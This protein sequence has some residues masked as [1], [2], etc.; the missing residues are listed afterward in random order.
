MKT[1]VLLLCAVVFVYIP[2]SP[3]R[4]HREITLDRVWSIDPVAAANSPTAS[5]SSENGDTTM[6]PFRIAD[7]FGYVAADGSHSYFGEVSFDVTIAR[8]GFVNY[9]SLGTNLV[10]QAPDGTVIASLPTRGYPMFLGDRLFVVATN[11]S[12]IEEWT[13]DGD[14][15]WTRDFAALVTSFDANGSSLIVGLLDGTVL[16]VDGDGNARFQKRFSGSRVEVIYGCTVSVDGTFLAVIHGLDPQWLTV[17]G[18]R[19]GQYEVIETVEL[20]NEFRRNR[21]VYLSPDAGVVYVGDLT[22]LSV[23][24]IEAGT[25]SA[26]ALPGDLDHYGAFDNQP[27]NWFSFASDERTMLAITTFDGRLVFRQLLDTA[28]ATPH[29]HRTSVYIGADRLVAR[30]DPVTR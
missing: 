10:V 4:R 17:M 13:V 12:R 25:S 9:S 21:P 11:R 7:G 22:G 18:Y 1:L 3:E 27:F 5:R 30:I 2:L 28:T 15:V 23:Y 26:I 6:V 24:H 16:L 8:T 14:L 20:A 29:T 19:E